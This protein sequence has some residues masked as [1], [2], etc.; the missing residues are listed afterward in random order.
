M[1]YCV[2]SLCVMLCV[3]RILIKIIYL[4]TYH[5]SFLSP[6]VIT[7]FQR[8]IPSAC[9]LNAWGWSFEFRPK[10][11]FISETVRDR[12]EVTIW[13]TSRKS[14]IT[15][16]SVSVPTLSDLEWRD[17]MGPIFRQVCESTL[18]PFDLERPNSAQL[19]RGETYTPRRS[20][21]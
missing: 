15:N 16:R 5:H 3:C 7:K 12:S 8:E 11:P 21:A 17:A 18:A 19:K 1:C 4:L 9:A 10:S 2:Y 13:I 20:I 14:W 6:T